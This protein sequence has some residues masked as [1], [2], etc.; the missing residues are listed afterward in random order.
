MAY[1][2]VINAFY[3]L[4]ANML[5]YR[6]IFEQ[7]IHHNIISSNHINLI[8]SQINHALKNA[9]LFNASLTE[10]TNLT[11]QGISVNFELL[12]V[13]VLNNNTD[14]LEYLKDILISLNHLINN[15]TPKLIRPPAKPF[16]C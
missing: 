15:H 9:L 16:L 3:F 1:T 8:L 14:I 11:K 5:K 10:I 4:V 12:P 2:D 6:L 13:S 7:S